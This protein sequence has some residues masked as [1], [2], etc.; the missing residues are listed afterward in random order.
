MLFDESYRHYPLCRSFSDETPTR[1]K[2]H[3]VKAAIQNNVDQSCIRVESLNDILVNIGR[4]DARLSQEEQATL[5][6]AAGVTNN[7]R[8]ISVDKIMQLM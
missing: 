6:Q 1:F 5:L 2:K 4:A 3:I 8:S 7:E